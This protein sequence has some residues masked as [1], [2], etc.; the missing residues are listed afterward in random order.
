MNIDLKD[1]KTKP[2]FLFYVKTNTSD[3]DYYAFNDFEKAIAKA[4]TLALMEFPIAF[5]LEPFEDQYH[6]WL[7]KRTFI[8]LKD[9]LEMD[10][11]EMLHC[12]FYLDAGDCLNISELIEQK[13]E[14]EVL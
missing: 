10:D 13:Q 11:K 6:E 7:M 14:G 3:F 5:I 1:R 8:Y 12:K 2:P 4:R 9:R